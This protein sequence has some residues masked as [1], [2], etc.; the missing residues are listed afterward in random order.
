MDT[1]KFT[2]VEIDCDLISEWDSFHSVFA[3]ALGFP[4]FYRRNMNAWVDCMTSLDAPEDG[5]TSVHAP[6]GGCLVLSLLNFRSLASRQPEIHAAIVESTA[7]VNFR[8][9]EVDDPPILVLSC[10]G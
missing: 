7:F 6:D 2:T 4:D 9:I 3:D 8:R 1:L 5:M 10:S